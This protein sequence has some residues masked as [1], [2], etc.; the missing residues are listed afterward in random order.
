MVV[1]CPIKLGVGFIM[2]KIPE[3]CTNEI[4][5]SQEPWVEKEESNSMPDRGRKYRIFH[6]QDEKRYSLKEEIAP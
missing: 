2:Q 4:V 3:T 6:K 5:R 1:C